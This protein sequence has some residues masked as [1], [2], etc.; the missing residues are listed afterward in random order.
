MEN[1]MLMWTI[2]DGKKGVSAASDTCQYWL[3]ETVLLETQG[4]QRDKPMSLFAK[5]N[6]QAQFRFHSCY[7]SMRE[8]MQ[9]AETLEN[10]A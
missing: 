9:A 10:P 2:H 4:P 5:P 8:A 3:C 7:N 1:L 6:G